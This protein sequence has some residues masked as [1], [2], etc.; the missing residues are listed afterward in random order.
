MAVATCGCS[1]EARREMRRKCSVRFACMPD[2]KEALSKHVGARSVRIY[3]LPGYDR[4]Q[5]WQP[6]QRGQPCAAKEGQA[7][8]AG[9]HP[10]A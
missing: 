1:V 10:M 4:F 8:N 7:A 6:N 2:L 3:I 5:T 9:S